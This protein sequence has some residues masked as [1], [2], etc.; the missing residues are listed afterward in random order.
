ESAF[1]KGGP[2][3]TTKV[4]RGETYSADYTFTVAAGTDYDVTKS[5]IVDYVDTEV[6]DLSDLDSVAVSGSY[7]WSPLGDEDFTL[8]QDAD[9]NLTIALS[10]AGIAKVDGAVDREWIVTIT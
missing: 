10:E 3:G 4:D 7:D 2:E 6:F 8:G 1:S 9:G 5:R